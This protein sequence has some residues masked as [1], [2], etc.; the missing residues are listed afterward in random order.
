MNQDFNSQFYTQGF[1]ASPSDAQKKG[2]RGFAITSLV[3]GIVG[4]CFICL[5]CC[6]WLSLLLGI[7]AIVFSILSRRGG[8][9]SGMAIAGLVLG[10]I[11]IV[12]F[13]VVFFSI[14]WFSSLTVTDL[15]AIFRE[16]FGEEFYEEFYKAYIEEFGTMEPALP[17]VN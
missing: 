12:L 1:D 7:G 13:L 6:Y 17:N 15:E 3:L 10:I 9:F 8:K 14:L 4:V 2:R 16:A 11:A 5:C